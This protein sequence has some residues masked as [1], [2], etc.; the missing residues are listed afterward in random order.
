M[1]K[2]ISQTIPCYKPNDFAAILHSDLSQTHLQKQILRNS[3]S[4]TA[5]LKG[6]NFSLSDSVLV[7][8]L[9]YPSPIEAAHCIK[10]I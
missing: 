8:V 4:Q 6:C 2:S 3:E 10:V 9:G 7:A 5:Q 1:A